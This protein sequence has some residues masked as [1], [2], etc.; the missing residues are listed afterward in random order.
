MG[1]HGTPWRFWCGRSRLKVRGIAVSPGLDK[2]RKSPRLLKLVFKAHISSLVVDM[3]SDSYF[4]LSICTK[5]VSKLR[6]TL[7]QYDYFGILHG[8]SDYVRNW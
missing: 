6:E 2:A 7:H 8:S 1:G 4:Y 5:P 3:A